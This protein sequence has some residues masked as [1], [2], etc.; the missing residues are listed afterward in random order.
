MLAIN[1]VDTRDIGGQRLRVERSA[2]HHGVDPCKRSGESEPR[3]TVGIRALEEG[4][5]IWADHRETN[6]HAGGRIHVFEGRREGYGR[7]LWRRRLYVLRCEHD[8]RDG[9]CGR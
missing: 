8:L 9:I 1:P 6:G 5:E 7:A 4:L 3:L 2:S